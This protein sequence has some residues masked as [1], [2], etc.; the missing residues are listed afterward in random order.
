MDELIR[1]TRAK[2]TER[3]TSAQE[4]ALLRHS[5]SDEILSLSEELSSANVAEIRPTLLEEIETMQRNIKEL[6][7]VKSYVQVVQSALVLRF[8]LHYAFH[9]WI[10]Y[11]HVLLVNRLSTP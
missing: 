1:D 9:I 7:S 5:V 3:L 2:A 4:L 6:E 8:A 10:N 11:N